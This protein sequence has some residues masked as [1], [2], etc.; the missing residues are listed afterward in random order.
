M[1]DAQEK[2][3]LM[4]EDFFPGITE[5]QDDQSRIAIILTNHKIKIYIPVININQKSVNSIGTL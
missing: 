2:D 1:E 5:E 4:E 3:S